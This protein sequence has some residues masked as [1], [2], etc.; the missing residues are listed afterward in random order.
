MSNTEMIKDLRVLTQAGMK[1]CKDALVESNWNLEKAVDLIKAKGKLVSSGSKTAAEGLVSTICIGDQ[2]TIGMVEVNCVTDFVANSPEF[3]QFCDHVSSV[4]AAYTLMNLP[5]QHQ[6]DEIEEL[7][8]TLQSTTKENIVVR[9]W[10]VEQVFD[11]N[12]EVFSYVHPNSGQ[13]K[14]G[15]LLSAMAMTKEYRDKP[16]FASLCNDLAMQIAAMNPLAISPDKLDPNVVERQRAIFQTQID[17]MNKP[18]VAH[19]KIMEG[20][21]NKWYT[22]VCLLNQESV[23]HPKTSVAKVIQNAAL[24]IGEVRLINFIRC[25]VGEGIDKPVDNFADDAVKMAGE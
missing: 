5:F 21:M 18:V 12:A 4:L 22:E 23:V 15:V 7:R 20:K 6:C 10:W 8:K 25:Q 3:R 11:D 1:D 9:R 16:E 19:A 13:G 14:I 24:S 17:N 2:K